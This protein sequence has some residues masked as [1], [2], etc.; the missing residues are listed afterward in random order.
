MPYNYHIMTN[1][2]PHSYRDEAGDLFLTKGEHCLLNGDYSGLHYFNKA[3]LLDPKNPELFFK[4]GLSLLECGEQESNEKYLK[5]AVRC[6]KQATN[7]NPHYFEAFMGW[8]HALYLLGSKK[9]DAQTLSNA[10]NKL[11][12]A[13]ALS[14]GQPADILA[15]LYIEYGNIWALLAEV[16]GEAIDLN[17][18]CKA[19]EKT[20]TYQEDLPA[21]FWHRFGDVSLK[22]GEKTNDQQLFLKAI[23]CYKNGISLSISSYE[24]WFHLSNALSTL[25]AYS[26]DEDHF[27][28]ANECF[29]TAINFASHLP[30]IWL[31]W[32]LL[33][34]DSGRKLKDSKRLSASL[35]KCQ[36][37]LRLATDK[38]PV[39]ALMAESLATLGVLT[40]R[41]ELIHEGQNKLSQ[42][43]E[44]HLYH[45]AEGICLH[46]LGDY[47]NDLDYY[48]QAIESFQAGLSL[49]RTSDALW[50]ALGHTYYT[51][52]KIEDEP[53]SFEKAARFFSRALNLKIRSVYHFS[54]AISLSRCAEIAK[55]E[56]TMQQAVFHFEQ[57]LHIQKNAIYLYPEWMF[58]YASALD[59]LADYNDNEEHYIKAIEILNHVLSLDPDYPNIHHQLA[60]VM[61]HYADLTQIPE[62][63]HRS[64]HHFRLAHT[65][66]KDSDGII[67]DWAIT[68]IN[69]TQSVDLRE[70]EIA[71]YCSEAEF[72]L[73]QAAKLG[74]IHAYFHLACLYSILR[75][76]D[77][78]IHFLEKAHAYGAL[79]PAQEL[80]EDDWLENLRQTDFFHSFIVKVDER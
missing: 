68:L 33:L 70:D 22:L 4:Q 45:H 46:A 28:Q 5:E 47:F 26:H 54:F 35:E 13:I 53:K 42:L 20:S 36:K 41:L 62:I 80:L 1:N 11:K 8:G 25:Y 17:L 43:G 78:S 48:Y 56:P 69:F 65:R 6:F 30:D 19:Y 51:V 2:L 12:K 44:N 61:G 34:G 52:A 49:D 73:I 38:S 66:S 63:F 16:S 76:L 57:A 67:L 27:I 37:A 18:A 3:A 9:N 29:Q 14:Q 23:N 64:I 15:D 58:E 50:Y 40:D 75:Q 31:K 72:K 79:P 74:N 7:L 21:T 10:K 32:A 55:D 60:L 59:S 71:S 39:Y 24:G 77:K